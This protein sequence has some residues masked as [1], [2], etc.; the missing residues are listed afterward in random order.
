MESILAIGLNKLRIRGLLID[1]D[2]T[3]ADSIPALRLAYMNFLKNFGATGTVAEFDR[4]NGPSLREI[5]AH[6]KTAHGLPGEH[7][8]LAP[9]YI[10]KI[11]EVYPEM[12]I[13]HKGAH[14]L[15]EYALSKKWETALVTSAGDRIARN[16]LTRH[17]LDRY[18]K[19][20]ITADDVLRTKPNPEIYLKA[21]DILGLEPGKAVAV[22]DSI[23]GVVASTSAGIGTIA[24]DLEDSLPLDDVPHILCRQPD[25]LSVLRYLKEQQP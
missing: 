15:C 2:G 21:L 6:L 25:L 22:E 20:I 18:F 5:I 16:F 14:S 7:Q 8:E 12:A 11:H 1:M 19:A 13:P 24:I 9:V 4:L 17:K 23:S 3:L 10:D